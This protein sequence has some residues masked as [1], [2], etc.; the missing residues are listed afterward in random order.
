M[1]DIQTGLYNPIPM[2][3]TQFSKP[4]SIIISYLVFWG[5]GVATGFCIGL[6]LGQLI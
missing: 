2:T 3:P 5:I 1:K 4:H 6:I